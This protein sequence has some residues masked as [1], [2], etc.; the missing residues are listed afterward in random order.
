MSGD[1]Y[2]GIVLSVIFVALLI[3][4]AGGKNYGVTAIGWKRN[5]LNEFLRRNWM[6]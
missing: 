6:S 5:R 2:A 3:F 1:I 4:V